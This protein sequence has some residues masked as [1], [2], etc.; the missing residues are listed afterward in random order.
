[1]KQF[2]KV[3]AGAGI[4]VLLGLSSSALASPTGAYVDVMGGGDYLT[5]SG[6]SNL[7]ID[8]SNGMPNP[9]YDKGGIGYTGRAAFGYFFNQD[10]LNSWAYGVEVGYNYFSPIETNRSDSFRTNIPGAPPVQESG[11]SKTNAWSTDADFVVSEDISENVSLLYKLGVGYESL[12]RKFTSPGVPLSS[13]SPTSTSTELDGFGLVGGIGMQYA[14]TKNFALRA[15]L[16]GMKGGKGI[17]YG[18]GLI[19]LVWS[20]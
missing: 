7:G 6:L 2:G 1:M 18:Q 19:G 14:F 9:Q 8:V 13:I 12:T 16:D 5:G 11:K 4:L 3:A 10:P 20:F 15:E 17:D